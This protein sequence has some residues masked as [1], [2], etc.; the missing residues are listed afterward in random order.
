M[1]R[2]EG[3]R[4]SG[5]GPEERS[6]LSDPHQI[7]VRAMYNI[8]QRTSSAPNTIKSILASQ[9]IAVS[10]TTVSSSA[11][12]FLRGELTPLGQTSSSPPG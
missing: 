7:A 6:R 3:S 1:P 12:T 4:V 8:P 11:D 10:R 2:R 9:F 5:T